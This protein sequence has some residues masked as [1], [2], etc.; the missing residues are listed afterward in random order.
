AH[1][2]AALR[3]AGATHVLGSVAELPALLRGVG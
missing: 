2:D 1:G 3:E